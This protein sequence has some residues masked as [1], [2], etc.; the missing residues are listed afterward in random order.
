MERIMQKQLVEDMKAAMK[1][2]EKPRLSV[3]RMLRAALKDKEIEVGHELDA[4]EALSVVTRLVKQRNDSAKQYADAGRDDL[5]ENE[6]A[7]IVFLQA[8]MPEPLSDEALAAIIDQAISDSGAAGMR[9]MGKVMAIV[10]AQAEGR[11]DMGKLSAI[12][13]ARLA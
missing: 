1:A 4:S 10:K 2:G 6:L 13:K 9:D 12:V 5:M 8:Y 3:I 11:A 7:E